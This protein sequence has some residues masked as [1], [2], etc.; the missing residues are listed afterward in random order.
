ML[1]GVAEYAASTQVAPKGIGS[2]WDG[3]A[4]VWLAAA[5]FADLM[6]LFLHLTRTEEAT[7]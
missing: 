5:V 7:N 2:D 4:S 6:G 3:G 1:V